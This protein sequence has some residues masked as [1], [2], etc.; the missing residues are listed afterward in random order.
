MTDIFGNERIM[1]IITN[2][3]YKNKRQFQ[4][5]Y[6]YKLKNIKILYKFKKE[7]F[8]NNIGIERIQKL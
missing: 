6:K 2:F 3:R 5:F 1:Q 7:I 4:I 8:Q